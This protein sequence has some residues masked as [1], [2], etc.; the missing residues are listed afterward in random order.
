MSE[1]T[2][3]WDP[4]IHY[5]LVRK[6]SWA[7]QLNEHIGPKSTKRI[8][9]QICGIGFDCQRPADADHPIPER[10]EI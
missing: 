6:T 9:T 3:R 2:T 1:I 7:V 4:G 8:T 5:G 10:R